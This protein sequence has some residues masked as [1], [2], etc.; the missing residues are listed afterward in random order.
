MLT[1]RVEYRY[2]FIEKLSEAKLIYLK[3]GMESEERS[4]PD[5]EYF[6]TVWGI[7]NTRY[8]PPVTS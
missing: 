5:A 7:G 1:P 4:P 8:N 6:D 2:T 3:L